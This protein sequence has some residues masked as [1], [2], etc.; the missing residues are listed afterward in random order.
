[1]SGFDIGLR[2]GVRVVMLVSGCCHCRG[3]N[4]EQHPA[5]DLGTIMKIA[6]N[7]YRYEPAYFIEHDFEPYQQHKKHHSR[8]CFEIL[9]GQY[10][11][12]N[13]TIYVNV[14]I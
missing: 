4:L 12:L 9:N 11:I 8:S 1:M 2:P 14:V 3:V 7:F 13:K 6:P 10:V 5:G